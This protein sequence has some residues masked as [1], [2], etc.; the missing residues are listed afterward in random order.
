MQPVVP[1]SPPPWVVRDD[2]VSERVLRFLT[3]PR[4]F[5]SE[6]HAFEEAFWCAVVSL[7]VV[8]ALVVAADMLHGFLGGFAQMESALSGVAGSFLVLVLWFHVV[9]KVLGGQGTFEDTYTVS[10]FVGSTALLALAVPLLIVVLLS[11]GGLS[12]YN[13]QPFGL[14]AG[15]RAL[16]LAST[17]LC[18][19]VVVWSSIVLWIGLARVHEVGVG[20]M[21]ALYLVVFVPMAARVSLL[22]FGS[23]LNVV[24]EVLSV[25]MPMVTALAI[26][27][28]FT[29]GLLISARNPG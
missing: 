25:G 13:A 28:V 20:A 19:T 27:V 7:G 9:L 8:G 21:T 10:V 22:V 4:Q 11:G 2:L 14:N 6:P 12:P 18:A 5:F 3:S 16:G 17:A 26:A 23:N 29:V 15:S 1:A 24:S